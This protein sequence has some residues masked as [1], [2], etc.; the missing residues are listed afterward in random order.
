MEETHRKANIFLEKYLICV[1]LNNYYKNSI[2]TNSLSFT[3]NNTNSN[4]EMEE[5]RENRKI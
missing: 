3:R 4:F 5:E 1:V 2:T